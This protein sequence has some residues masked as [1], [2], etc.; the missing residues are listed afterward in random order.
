MKLGGGV[1]LCGCITAADVTE[2][3]SQM[4]SLMFCSILNERMQPSVCALSCWSSFQQFR[5][6]LQSHCCI[7]EK[8]HGKIDLVNKSFLIKK[9]KHLCQIPKRQVKHHS[10]ANILKKVQITKTARCYWYTV[11][12]STDK[13][14]HSILLLR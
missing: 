3:H 13:K 7:S 1:F 2:L 14:G 12:F 10:P 8:E 6:P 4:N 11:G 9:I 5:I